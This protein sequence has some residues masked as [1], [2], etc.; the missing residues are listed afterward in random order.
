MIQSR[1]DDAVLVVNAGSSTLKFALYPHE[2]SG[3]SSGSYPGA[4][5]GGQIDGLQPGGQLRLCPADAPARALA[6]PAEAGDHARFDLAL[7]AMREFIASAAPQARVVA[8]AHR[9]VHGGSFCTEPVVLDDALLARLATLEPLAPLHQ[10]YNL[11]GVRALQRAYPELAQVGCFDTAFHAGMPALEQRYALPRALHDEGLR[12]YGFHGLSYEYL[13][14]VLRRHSERAT[15]RVLMAHLG[16]G[17]SLCAARSGR[18]IA[19]SMGF[20][21]LDGLMMGSRCGQLDPG[22]LLHLWRAG[23]ELPKVERLLYKES[24]LLGVSGLSGDLRQLRAAARDG[25]AEAVEAIAL[26]GHRLKRESGAL[27]AALG[28]LDLLAFTGGIGEHDAAVR[29]DLTEGLAYLGLRLD[30][31]ANQAADGSRSVPIHAPD[32][33]VQIWVVPTDEGR[34]AAQAAWRLVGAEA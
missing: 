26:F 3:S 4:Y 14:Q 15:G 7:A 9:I 21:A 27:V 28:G 30:A 29:A 12:R 16:S 24:G 2:S 8:V 17:A 18:S 25:H 33:R 5:A 34:V 22:I 32:S 11:A 20:S 1:S 13:M 23:W 10:P 19:S 31:E 6:A